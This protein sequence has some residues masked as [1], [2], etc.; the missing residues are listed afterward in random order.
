MSDAEAKELFVSFNK[1]QRWA[2]AHGTWR[3]AGLPAMLSSFYPLAINPAKKLRAAL[4]K[5]V[6]ERLSCS[7]SKIDDKDD[8]LAALIAAEDQDGNRF[9]REQLI[10]EV[11]IMFLAGHETSASALAWC[12]YL[13]AHHPNIQENIHFEIQEALGKE[14]LAFSHM[15]MLRLVR[16]CFRETLRLYPPIPFVPRKVTAT[17]KWR[18]KTIKP[19]ETIFV[20]LWL[21]HRRSSL[22]KDADDF[23]PYRF[24]AADSNHCV[25]NGFLPFSIGPRACIGASFAMQEATVVIARLV[26]NFKFEPTSHVPKPVARL[27]LRSRNGILLRVTKRNG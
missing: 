4:A 5:R 17:E 27:T 25:K 23:D 14:P 1:F 11:A 20:S 15:K 2:F 21:L 13:L 24:S 8:L 19:G 12:F 10:D 7:H 16:D 9:N 22:W 18:D 26:Q 6:D 3:M